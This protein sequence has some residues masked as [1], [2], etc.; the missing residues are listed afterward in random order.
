MSWRNAARVRAACLVTAAVAIALPMVL[1]GSSGSHADRRTTPQPHRQSASMNGVPEGRLVLQ[2]TSGIEVLASGAFGRESLGGGRI[3][4]Y[5]VSPDGAEV[6]ATTYESEPTGYTREN[7]LLTIDTATGDRRGLVRAAPKQDLG[8]A[9]WSPDGSKV[10][11]RLTVLPADPGLRRPRGVPDQTICTL[12]S[13]GSSPRCF[14]D[15]GTVDDFAWSPSGHE[16]VV[17]G[18]GAHVPLRILDLR[19]GTV[20][21]FVSPDDPD[22]DAAIGH[23]P[24]TFV[25]SGW[26]SSGSYVSTDVGAP[27][28]FDRWGRFVMVGRTT[29]EFAEIHAWSPTADLLA[30]AVGAPPYAITDLYL[31]D[32][33]AR[34]DRLLYSTGQG[35]R[36]PIIFDAGWSPSGR[37]LAVATAKRSIYGQQSI[38]IIDMVRGT[39]TRVVHLG[40]QEIADPLVGWAP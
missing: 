26:S 7:E 4:A 35:A 20:S 32:P 10:A 34:R 2:S 18:V 6:L 23:P 22:L 8:P 28:V 12:H 37:W 38:R 17:D 25:F 30:H 19:T 15:L 9:S 39:T 11:Y 21:P 27:A 29:R 13:E 1:L 14:P 24:P 31:L 16:I 33:A 36:A 5:G 40:S 3:V